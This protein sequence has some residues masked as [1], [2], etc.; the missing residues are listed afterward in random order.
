MNKKINYIIWGFIFLSILSVFFLVNKNDVNLSVINSAEANPDFICIQDVSSQPCTINPASCT[1]WINSRRTCNWTTATQ[2]AY[3]SVRIWC[4]EW[5]ICDLEQ[6]PQE[7]QC[8]VWLTLSNYGSY[9]WIG[10]DWKICYKT[11]N[12]VW[13]QYS[14]LYD[15]S[16]ESFIWVYYVDAS[17]KPKT[18]PAWS[19]IQNY[20]WEY[21][22][23]S[24]RHSNNF[25]YNTTSCT[26][27]Q[28]DTTPPTWDPET[29]YE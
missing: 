19:W 8:P 28:T 3:Y 20:V 23:P 5:P 21:G 29:T 10:L 1:P 14:N 18:C 26:I 11:T 2:V 15:P 27:V 7:Y 4:A 6:L 17:L 12:F 24:W 25:T 22:G 13:S 16:S 9:T